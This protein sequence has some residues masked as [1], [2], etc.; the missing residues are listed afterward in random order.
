MEC[1]LLLLILVVQEEVKLIGIVFSEF[2]N[3]FYREKVTK[4][5]LQ[6]GDTIKIGETKMKF[7]GE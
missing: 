7:R 4:K 1:N 6:D 3:N 2:Q 5:V